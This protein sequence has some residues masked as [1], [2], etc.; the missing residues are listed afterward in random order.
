MDETWTVRH[1]LG[2]KL[3]DGWPDRLAELSRKWLL[4][5]LDMESR[6]DPIG[7]YGR[8]WI[9]GQELEMDQTK[10]NWKTWWNVHTIKWCI[11][12]VMSTWVATLPSVYHILSLNCL[13]TDQIKRHKNFANLFLFWSAGSMPVRSDRYIP[14]LIITTIWEDLPWSVLALLWSPLCQS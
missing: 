1:T 3:V 13:E 5:D 12:V 14:L 7:N 11:V 6:Y 9:S 2:S 8:K 10:P 4:D